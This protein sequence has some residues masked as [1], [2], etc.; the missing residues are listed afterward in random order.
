MTL[1]GKKVKQTI[2]VYGIKVRIRSELNENMTLYKYGRSV[3]L[4]QGHSDLTFSNLFFLR[5]R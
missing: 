3:T 5:N 1:Y 4:V 2:I